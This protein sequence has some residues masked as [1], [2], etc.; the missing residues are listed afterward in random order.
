MLHQ[1][2]DPE[3]RRVQPADQKSDEAPR[4]G[5][6][7]IATNTTILVA[8]IG[9][10]ATGAGA[11][12]TGWH[13]VMLEKSKQEAAARL[14]RQDFETKLIFR[15]VEGSDSAEERARNLKFFL[16]AGFL[17]DPDNKIR[18]LSPGRYPSVGSPSFECVSTD[19]AGHII[20]SDLQ[21]SAKDKIMADL[22]RQFR[23][24]VDPQ[25]RKQVLADQ[26]SWLAERNIC[27]EV[28]EKAVSCMME[29]YEVRIGE[30]QRQLADRHSAPRKPT[31]DTAA[32]PDARNSPA[33]EP[34]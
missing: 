30:L 5:F 17:S 23:G 27:I 33:T 9:A 1:A 13:N 11:V 34:R 14:A 24:L 21:L 22:Y 7:S 8:V 31:P 3:A 19:T 25:A 12:V 20:C 26:R 32:S 10:I 28:G 29:K 4:A 15:A 18:N 2:A 6:G 16:D